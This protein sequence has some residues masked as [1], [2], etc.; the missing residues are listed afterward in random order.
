MTWLD[1]CRPYNRNRLEMIKLARCGAS[2]PVTRDSGARCFNAPQWAIRMTIGDRLVV[3]P[4]CSLILNDTWHIVLQFLPADELASA[5]AVNRH[6]DRAVGREFQRRRRHQAEQWRT[7]RATHDRLRHALIGKRSRL[8][9]LTLIDLDA[10]FAAALDDGDMD[11]AWVLVGQGASSDTLPLSVVDDDDGVV[12]VNFASIVWSLLHADGDTPLLMA[13]AKAIISAAADR[14][15]WA[16]CTSDDGSTAFD[17]IMTTGVRQYPDRAVRVLALMA[18]AGFTISNTRAMHRWTD[19]VNRSSECDPGVR[20]LV[21][22][23]AFVHQWFDLSSS[24]ILAG[25]PWN[26]S[27]T[28]LV[29]ASHYTAAQMLSD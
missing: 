23:M 17:L 12:R 6:C 4:D 19:F 1:A 13:K 9:P 24:V 18:S 28:C 5:R 25:G 15:T 16:V 14:P 20:R 8:S 2:A 11:R 27:A 22:R 21:V 29:V 3:L 7:S 10:R 26:R